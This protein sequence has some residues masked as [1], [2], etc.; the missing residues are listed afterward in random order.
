MSATAA[1]AQPQPELSAWPQWW[2]EFVVSCR[3]AGAVDEEAL[4]LMHSSKAFH[5]GCDDQLASL[6]HSFIETHTPM[7]EH[8]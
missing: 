3:D 8:N 6:Y 2:P 7:G 1:A 5:D 4:A